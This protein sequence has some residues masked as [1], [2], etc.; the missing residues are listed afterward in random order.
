MFVRTSESLKL[1]NYNTYGKK[2]LTSGFVVW[3]YLEAQ[4]LKFVK[5]LVLENDLILCIEIW[6]CHTLLA[7]LVKII[8]S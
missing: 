5:N 1:E 3:F 4:I 8:D 2:Y 6:K 7:I